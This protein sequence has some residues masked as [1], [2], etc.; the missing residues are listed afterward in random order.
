[1]CARFS[2]SSR[3]R[4]VG[5]ENA[6]TCVRSTLPGLIEWRVMVLSRLY[7]GVLVQGDTYRF[8]EDGYGQQ[9]EAA[10]ITQTSISL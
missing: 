1:M 4:F 6:R 8:C 2:M 7:Q 3:N 9:E 5:V 10:Y